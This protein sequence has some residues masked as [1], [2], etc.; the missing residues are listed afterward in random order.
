MT[1]GKWSKEEE[2]GEKEKEK[3]EE[4]EKS[5]SKV[6]LPS[7][8][9]IIAY[10]LDKHSIYVFLSQY[11]SSPFTIYFFRQ[12]FWADMSPPPICSLLECVETFKTALKI[13]RSRLS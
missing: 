2:E 9:T 6:G 1:K 12:Y 3:K 5:K 10:V 13:F 8:P 4:E 11:F 7:G